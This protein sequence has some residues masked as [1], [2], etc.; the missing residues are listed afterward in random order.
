M[1]MLLALEPEWEAKFDP[2][3]FGFRPGY[4]TF[5]AK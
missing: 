4:S 2:N 5:D 1:L 3:S